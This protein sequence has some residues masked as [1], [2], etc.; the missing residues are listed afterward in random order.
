M[1]ARGTV[2]GVQKKG[3]N[4]KRQ[5]KKKANKIEAKAIR[6]SNIRLKTIIA[7]SL[8]APGA[9]IVRLTRAVIARGEALLARGRGGARARRGRIS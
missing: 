5:K 7:L 2:L 3:R 6:L 4:V 8:R 1:N 9:P